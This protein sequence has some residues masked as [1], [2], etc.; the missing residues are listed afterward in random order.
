MSFQRSAL[1]AS[2]LLVA[3]QVAAQRT[4][5]VD[6]DSRVGTDF[7]D[8]PPAITAARD[9][10]TIL[11]RYHGGGY[12]LPSLVTKALTI[13]G[14]R[15]PR[16]PQYA[17]NATA[18]TFEIRGIP[19]G[20]TFAIKR[21]ASYGSPTASWKIIA[22]QGGVHLEDVTVGGSLQVTGA[23]QVSLVRSTLGGA[24]AMRCWSGSNVVATECTLV[25]ASSYAVQV[26]LSTL[27]VAFGTVTGADSQSVGNPPFEAI[28]LAGGTLVVAGDATTLVSAGMGYYP[29]SAS[30]VVATTGGT[31]DWDPR[32]RLVSFGGAPRISGP[33]TVRT[34]SL[35][36]LRASGSWPGSYVSAEVVAN[37]GDLAVFLASAP[38]A[39]VQAP[40]FGELWLDPPGIFF[41]TGG[42][43]GATGRLPVLMPIDHAATLGLAVCLQAV[44][45]PGLDLTLSNPAVVLLQ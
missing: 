15:D 19:A 16:Y 18:T 45:G 34:R 23:S 7:T 26:M 12:T 8:I 4:W 14:E 11:V 28:Q 40:P 32:A 39:P 1:V 21:I 33:A 22:C 36:S 35:P 43:L 24:P 30:A 27:T 13:L 17:V 44:A 41:V 37:P 10:D 3:G 5:I 6:R 20:R 9:G 38:A 2:V 25:G 42:I 29:T 31:V